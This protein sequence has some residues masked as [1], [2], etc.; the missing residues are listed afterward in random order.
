MVVQGI[1]LGLSNTAG[2]LAGVFGTAATGYILQ[3]GQLSQLSCHRPHLLL[4]LQTWSISFIWFLTNFGCR[5]LQ[6]H[7]MMYLRWQS[8]CT[9]LELLFGTYFR[10]ESSFLIK[11]YGVRWHEIVDTDQFF[12]SVNRIWALLARVSHVDTLILHSQIALE[13]LV[14]SNEFWSRGHACFNSQGFPETGLCSRILGR[15][16]KV[17]TDNE[18]CALSNLLQFLFMAVG[19]L[20][21]NIPKRLTHWSLFDTVRSVRSLILRHEDVEPRW[22]Y[23][24]MLVR[25][26]FSRTP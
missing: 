12:N 9:Y 21:R 19:V 25:L 18:L 8:V 24:E 4:Q 26:S 10:P 15:P 13:R 2:V 16:Y 20:S 1:L 14:I 7:G 22:Q 6:V 3:H 23:D 11:G 17:K 5:L